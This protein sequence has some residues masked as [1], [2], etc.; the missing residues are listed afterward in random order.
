MNIGVHGY[1]GYGRN[2]TDTSQPSSLKNSLQVNTT[3]QE[4]QVS[5]RFGNVGNYQRHQPTR[6]GTDLTVGSKPRKK[7][8]KLYKPFHASIGGNGGILPRKERWQNR[9][10]IQ[11]APDGSRAA[12]SNAPQMGRRWESSTYN[13]QEYRSQVHTC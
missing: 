11:T 13:Q 5:L 8:G 9:Q 6:E 4:G 10:G 3:R 7:P 2:T 1:R 12:N